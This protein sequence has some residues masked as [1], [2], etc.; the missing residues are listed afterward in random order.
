MAIFYILP[1]NGNNV[2][3]V[4]RTMPT[5]SGQMKY[6]IDSP[7][8]GVRFVTIDEFSRINVTQRMI[9]VQK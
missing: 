6:I 2:Q 1:K 5:G 7:R 4:R 3:E 9:R 8:T